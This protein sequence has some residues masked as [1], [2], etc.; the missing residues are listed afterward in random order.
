MFSACLG[1]TTI[2][3]TGAPSRVS[4]G[5]IGRSDSSWILLLYF[6]PSFVLLFGWGL[7]VH[8]TSLIGDARVMRDDD[9]STLVG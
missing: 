9:R 6:F 2:G 4:H 1:S 7:F 5:V 8:L 3:T